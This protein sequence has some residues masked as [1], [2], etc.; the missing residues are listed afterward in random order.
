M[1]AKVN[2]VDQKTYN[3]K[4]T[5]KINTGIYQRWLPIKITALALGYVFQHISRVKYTFNVMV[6]LVMVWLVMVDLML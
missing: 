6:W 4:S 2:F 3:E 5:V 1:S